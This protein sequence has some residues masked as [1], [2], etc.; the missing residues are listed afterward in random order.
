[1]NLTQLS[2]QLNISA[3][4]LRALIK[5][6]FGDIE[7]SQLTEIQLKELQDNL[8]DAA[9]LAV[10]PPAE[11]KVEIQELDILDSKETEKIQK[12]IEVLGVTRLKKINDL[13][14]KQ[15]VNFA[16]KTVAEQ[17]EV[18]EVTGKQLAND[19]GAFLQDQAIALKAVTEESMTGD[20]MI[21]K[22]NLGEKFTITDEDLEMLEMEL[23]LS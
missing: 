21:K 22:V 16:I 7:V 11:R 10:L 15:L 20:E 12:T 4:K 2:K 1:M 5:K 17:R 3:A 18:L 19:R 14:Q 8:Q 13:Y 6:H 23:Q 9:S